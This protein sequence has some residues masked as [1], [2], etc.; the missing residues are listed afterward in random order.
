VQAQHQVVIYS[1]NKRP[2][3]DPNAE[4]TVGGS[5]QIGLKTHGAVEKVIDQQSV[6]YGLEKLYVSQAA[7]TATSYLSALIA[8]VCRKGPV[9]AIQGRME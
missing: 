7:D 3:D 2:I 9:P 4:P 5:L 6:N 8:D 1:T